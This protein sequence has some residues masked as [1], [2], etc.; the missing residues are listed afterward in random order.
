MVNLPPNR[1]LN[2]ESAA[3]APFLTHLASPLISPLSIDASFSSY[4]VSNTEPSTSCTT[5]T[6]QPK[7]PGSKASATVTNSRALKY[8][9][10]VKAPTYVQGL[11]ELFSAAGLKQRK[12][13]R[14]GKYFRGHERS[15]EARGLNCSDLGDM[16]AV[17]NNGNFGME[18]IV[19]EEQEKKVEWA[20]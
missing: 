12:R 11:S 6:S 20:I 8:T 17:E 5:S 3:S 15:E 7:D 9:Y 19:E 18:M 4:P 13:R 2:R 14:N 16:G 10:G 1:A